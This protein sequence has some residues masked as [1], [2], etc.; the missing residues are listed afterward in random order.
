MN[1]T[2]V[3]V[4]GQPRW[5]WAALLGSLLLWSGLS[6]QLLI[7]V[8][9]Y[10]RTY[11]DFNMDLPTP[12]ELAL[13]LARWFTTVWPLVAPVGLVVFTLA[14]YALR[15]LDSPRARLGWVLAMVLTPA[16]LNLALWLA[17]Y[18]PLRGMLDAL[19]R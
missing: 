9:R 17:C 3:R 5:V 8:P 11:R 2:P 13:A 7:L 19:S 12:T 15:R 6:M 14:A 4:M 18:W 1:T 16:L 10:E